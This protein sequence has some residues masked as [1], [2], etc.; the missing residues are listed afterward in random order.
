MEPGV[1]AAAYGVETAAEGALGAAVAIAKSTMPLKAAWTRIPT[2]INL[3]RSSHSLSIIEG[4]AYIFGGEETPRTPVDNHIHVFTL[5]SSEHDDVDYQVIQA[6]AVSSD[7]EVP[8]PRVGHTASVVSDRIYVFGGRGGKAMKPLQEDGRVWVFDTR[9]N[10]WSFL[11]P[12]EGSSYPEPRSYHTSASTEH[13]LSRPPVPTGPPSGSVASAYTKSTP[14]QKTDYTENPLGTSASGADDHG[15][16]FV[17]GGC[18]SSG[19][20][21][22]VWAF[23]IASRTWYQYTDAPGPSSWGTKPLRG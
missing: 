20:V 7:E 4:K 22:D 6:Q 9:L 23:D 21:A 8:P 2:S 3:P 19:R 16:I 14:S 15:T 17:H 10:L 13:P 11:D 5:P 18:P 1:A 12:A